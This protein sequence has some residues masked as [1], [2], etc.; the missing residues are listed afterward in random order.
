MIHGDSRASLTRK[1]AQ[2]THGTARHGRYLAS[3][4]CLLG[5]SRRRAL[6]TLH[7]RLAVGIASTGAMDTADGCAGLISTASR[8]VAALGAGSGCPARVGAHRG[9]PLARRETELAV[10]RRFAQVATAG[11]THETA[12]RRKQL[13]S[14]VQRSWIDRN[15]LKTQQLINKAE[16]ARSESNPW[17]PTIAHPARCRATSVWQCTSAYSVKHDNPARHYDRY[18]GS[19]AA[20]VNWRRQTLRPVPW[21]PSR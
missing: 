5:P 19:L 8:R 6:R 3:T 21:L 12:V 13:R 16:S 9:R 20:S 7:Q 14:G 2:K 17:G 18:L 4:R 1:D 15:G 10:P 11:C